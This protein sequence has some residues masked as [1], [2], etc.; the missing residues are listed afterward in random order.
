ML[1]DFTR[2]KRLVSRAP[3]R[4]KSPGKKTISRKIKLSESDRALIECNSLLNPSGSIFSDI[5]LDPESAEIA[6]IIS[7]C[8]KKKNTISLYEQYRPE[9]DEIK[10]KTSK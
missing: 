1:V 10:D 6:A 4:R 3:E 2:K 5:P 7:P 9:L 8:R